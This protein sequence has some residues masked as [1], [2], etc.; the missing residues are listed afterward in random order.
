MVQPTVTSPQDIPPSLASKSDH[1]VAQAI[2]IK[3]NIKPPKKRSRTHKLKEGRVM[4]DADE[5]AIKDEVVAALRAATDEQIEFSHLMRSLL[6]LSCR[7]IPAIEINA[8][9]ASLP[10]RPANN[11]LMALAAFEDELGKFLL[12]AFRDK[13]AMEVD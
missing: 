10:V 1:G 5:W 7:A 11:D 12:L 6:A 13:K 8:K 9:H 3:E 2:E 4:L